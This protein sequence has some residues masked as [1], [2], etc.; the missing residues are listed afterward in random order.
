MLGNDW[1]ELLKGEMEKEYFDKL[2]DFV[3]E[4]NQEKDTYPKM[5]EI[6]NPFRHTA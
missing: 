1:D 6:L 2:F 4:Q 5:K 3:K